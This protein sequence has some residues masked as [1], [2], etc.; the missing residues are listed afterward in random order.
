VFWDDLN[1]GSEIFRIYGGNIEIGFSRSGRGNFLGAWVK[2]EVR[3]TSLS[4]YNTREHLKKEILR[5]KCVENSET[6][7]NISLMSKNY[8]RE[9][10][11]L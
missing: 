4:F 11:Y 2:E 6:K 1:G 7:F 8:E 3:P 5:E 9:P 10:S